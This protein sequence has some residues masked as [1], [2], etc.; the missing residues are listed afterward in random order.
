M[1]HRNGDV[2][3][4]VD[5]PG[6]ERDETARHQLLHEHDAA[7]ES[8]IGLPADVEAEVHFLE[9]RVEW[10][11][12]S[13]DARPPEEESDDAGVEPPVP[14]VELGAGRDEGLEERTLHLPVQHREE[15]PLG[16]QE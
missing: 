8:A 10:H 5:A 12:D 4:V 7:P 14:V 1:R 15:T 9:L 3:F 11:G 2:V 6:D 16:R 13:E